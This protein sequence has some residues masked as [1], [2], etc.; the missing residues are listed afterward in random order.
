MC[1]IKYLA[2][3]LLLLAV[4][5]ISAQENKPL[6]L[7]LRFQQETSEGTQRFHRITRTEQWAPQAT[8]VIVC[9]LWDSHHCV[10]AVRRVAELA[11]RI[12]RFV[13]NLRSQGVTV[14]HAPSEC[15]DAYEDH[16]A[17]A[18]AMQIPK[19]KSLP[20]EIARWCDRIPAEESVA[21]PVDQSAGG[22]DDEVEDH[23]LWAARLEAM[24]RNPKAPWLKQCEAV[25]IAEHDYISDSGEEIWSI[26]EQHQVNNIILVGVHANVCVLGR[27]FGLRRL[28]SNG[29]NVVLARDLTDTMYDPNAWPYVSHFSGTDLIID[30]I[31]RF[32]CPTIS[33]NQ[34]LG[35]REFR[36]SGDQRPRLVMLVAE[37]EYKTEITLPKFAAQHLGQHFSVQFCFGSDTSR[38]EIPGLSAVDEADALLISVRRRALPTADLQRIRNFIARGKPV[39]GI[40]TASH[41]FS[42]RDQKPTDGLAV[43]PEFDAEVWGGSYAGHYGNDLKSTVAL[44]AGAQQHPIFTGLSLNGFQPGGSL[45]KTAPLAAGSH[46]LLLGKLDGE[47]EHPVAWTFIRGDGGRSFYTSLG[48]IDDFAQPQF[49]ALLSAGIHWATGLDTPS[50]DVIKSQQAKYAAGQGKQRK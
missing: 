35:D 34:I 23:Q 4:P 33:S 44:T 5:S 39:I 16:P 17:R 48:H 11:P 46:N 14:I 3:A 38:S 40:R 1:N 12:D 30:H 10:N 43:W 29:K 7:D 21:Y 15:M 18:R 26:L 41:A 6:A 37:D 36:F 22:E 50:L 45:Y 32:V 19:S 47:P 20:K 24:G 13:S 42:L 25:E 31:E 8:A 9:D 2:T 27:P 49:A 28:A